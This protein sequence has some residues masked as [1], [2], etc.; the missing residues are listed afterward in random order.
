MILT[1]REEGQVAFAAL[2]ERYAQRVSRWLIRWVGSTGE[3]EDLVQQVFFQL[4]RALPSFRGDST[5]STFI[6]GITRNVAVDHLRKRKRLPAG[7]GEASLAEFLDTGPSPEE[8]ACKREELRELFSLLPHLSELKQRA[9]VLVAIN[10][11]SL[12]DAAELLNARPEA[13][14]QRVLAARREL[15]AMLN[16]DDD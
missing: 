9:F 11:M 12:V 13:V 5:M 7:C 4:H 2:Y 14:R 1:D 16:R 3:R 8:L 6:G 10:G 15:L